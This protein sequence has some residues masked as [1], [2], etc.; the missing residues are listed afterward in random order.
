[1]KKNE[2]DKAVQQLCLAFPETEEFISHG[3]PNYRVRGARIFAM[4]AVNH[5][6]DGRIALWLNT[7]EGMQDSYVRAEPKH[8]FIPPYV[9][10]GGWLGVRLDAGLAWKRVA[11]LVRA[12]YE[13]TVPARLVGKLKATPDVPAPKQKITV[14]DV[15]P[16]NTPRGKSILASMRKICLALPDT[17]EGLQFGQSVWRAGKKVFAQAHCYDERW[18][19]S[20][21]V[22]VHAQLLMTDDPRYTIPPYMG[23]NGW[24]ALD[25]TKKHS[26]RELKPLALESYRHFALKKMLAK[27]PNPTAS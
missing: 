27:L 10:P 19:V 4:Y 8:F 14:A 13:V 11:P 6:G 18:R 25:V 2:L 24:I 23:H 7:P 1:M 17:S 12:A 9:G 5:H 3:M 21:W 20:F 26:E 16:R 22:G 15:D